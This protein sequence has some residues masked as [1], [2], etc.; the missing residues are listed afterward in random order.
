MEQDEVDARVSRKSRRER[1]ACERWDGRNRPLSSER[2]ERGDEGPGD[3]WMGRPQAPEIGDRPT[4]TRAP[5]FTGASKVARTRGDPY[6]WA[7]LTGRYSRASVPP[8]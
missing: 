4:R 3:G 1:L 8:T 7:R 5:L 6:L 2:G